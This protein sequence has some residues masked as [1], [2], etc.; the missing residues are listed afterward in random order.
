MI[1]VT[2]M[3]RLRPGV[4]FAVLVCLSPLVALVSAAADRTPPSVEPATSFPAVDIHVDE[5]VAI[6]ADPYDTHEKAAI[7]RADYLKYGFM[8]IRLIVTNNGDKPISLAEARIHFITADGDK[9]P[10]ALPGDIE[11]RSTTVSNAGRRIALPAP[12]PPIHQK[13]KSKTKEIDADFAS[14][15]YSALAVEPHTTRAGFLFYD[16]REIEN[17][18]K[19]AKLYLRMLRSSDG[20]DLFFFEIP[21]D[22]YLATQP[23]LGKRTSE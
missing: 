9:I 18:L 3:M 22:K 15:E 7:F 19:G 2:F 14:F 20:K 4:L 11:R 13:V 23:H 5:H 12:L 10:A 17:P 21:F 16:M 1:I 6:A 8:P